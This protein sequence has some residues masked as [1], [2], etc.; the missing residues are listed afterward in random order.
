MRGMK[1]ISITLIALAMLAGCEAPTVTA[2]SP[3]VAKFIEY[4]LDEYVVTHSDELLGDGA[5]WWTHRYK[6]RPGFTAKREDVAKRIWR[7]LVNTGWKPLDPPRRKYTVSRMFE[8]AP[9]DL[10]F[11]HGPFPG[12]GPDAFHIQHIYVSPGGSVITCYFE[13]KW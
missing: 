13:S 3:Q 8:T 7:G 10:H 1:T 4:S 5:A 2:E 11:R 12:E 6:L 9:D